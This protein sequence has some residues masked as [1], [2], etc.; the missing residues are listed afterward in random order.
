M[1]LAY[2]DYQKFESRVPGQ[3]RPNPIAISLSGIVKYPLL[4]RLEIYAKAGYANID[5]E[6]DSSNPFYSGSRD[7]S[8]AIYGVGFNYTISSNWKVRAG[9]ERTELNL[10]NIPAGSF[11]AKSDGDLDI[12]TIGL[13]RA[14]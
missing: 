5:S 7:E 9:A 6:I 11:F 2:T 13:V 4:D 14:F 1:E 10:G 12:L 8:N 3:L